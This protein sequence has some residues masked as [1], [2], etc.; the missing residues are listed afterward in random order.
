MIRKNPAKTALHRL[1]L[2]YVSATRK[3]LEGYFQVV[4]DTGTQVR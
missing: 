3:A 2:S 1:I 4:M